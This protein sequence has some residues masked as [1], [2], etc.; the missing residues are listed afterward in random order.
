[1]ELVTPI[2]LG[3]LVLQGQGFVTLISSDGDDRRIVNA[4]RVSFDADLKE[5][6]PD[7]DKK[8]INYL[9]RNDHTS[10]LEHVTFTFL[11]ECPIFIARQWMRHRTWSYNEVSGR[12]T[13][14]RMNFYEPREWRQQS[15]SNKQ[16]SAGAIQDESKQDK[17]RVDYANFL[18]YAQDLYAEFI[19]AGVSRE[20]ARILL[21]NSLMTRF[22]A[23]VD[24]HNLLRFIQ[25]RDHAH[26]QQEIREYAIAM[27]ELIQPIVPVAVEAWNTHKGAKNE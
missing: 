3:L 23:T 4:A 11:I 20:M 6:D 14:P 9:I 22:Y 19:D 26:A 25:L 16:A 24:L 27:R 21:P 12:Y 2:Q 7:R 1:M 15:V 18:R 13:E 8:L 5:H 17:L 10:P